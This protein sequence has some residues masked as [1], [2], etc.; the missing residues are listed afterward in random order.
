MVVVESEMKGLNL[1]CKKTECL[2]ISKTESP[3]CILKVNDQVIKQAFSFNYLGSIITEDA[4]CVNEVKRR[5]AVAKSTFSKLDKVLRNRSLS[6]KVRLRVLDCYVYP[7]LMYGSEAWSIT[8]DIKRHLESCEMWF[9]RKMMKIPWTD[10]V[11]NEGVLSRAQVKRKLMKDIRVRQ[12]NFLGHIIRRDG[13]ENLAVTGRIEGKKSGGRRRV[14]WMSSV[15]G[16]LQERG[17][18]HQKVELIERTRNRKLWHDMIAYV[19]GYGT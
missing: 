19:Q 13:L 3:R 9:L 10:K 4:R 17:V 6:M 15:K 18:K 8:S 16:W 7:V 1:N 12:L 14:T 11:C 2:V 5:I